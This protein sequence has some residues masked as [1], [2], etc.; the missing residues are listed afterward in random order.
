[1]RWLLLVAC[2]TGCGAAIGGGDNETPDAP[3]NPP[4]I[5][6]P[7]PDAPPPDARLCAG[8]DAAMA[9][10]DGSCFVRF[11]Q[12]LSFAAAQA[13]CVAFGSQLAIL[14]T[15][16]RDATAALLVGQDNVWI[17]LTDQVV[18]NTFVWVDGSA[19]VFTNFSTGEPNNANGQF[20]EDCIMYAGSR[21]GWDD[22]PCAAGAPALGEYAYL[23]MF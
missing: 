21:P 10:G 6:A 16:A 5:D 12:V 23:C 20:Q 19:L 17:G 2:T 1:M 14:N 15:A 8:G 9:S 18:E 22:R 11:N 3:V 4:P 7:D 13:A